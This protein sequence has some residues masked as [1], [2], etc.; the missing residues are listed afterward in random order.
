MIKDILEYNNAECLSCA[1]SDKSMVKI[2]PMIFCQNCWAKEFK[3]AD[4]YDTNSP[5]YKKWIKIYKG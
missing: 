4:K 2:G 1:D 3:K 5:V